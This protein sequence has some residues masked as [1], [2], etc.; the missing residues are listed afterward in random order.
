M[1]STKFTSA[2]VDEHVAYA[3]H[4]PLSQTEPDTTSQEVRGSLA[5]R[6]PPVNPFAMIL[7]SGS[8][9]G[10]RKLRQQRSWTCPGPG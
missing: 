5:P 8:S 7:T 6:Q 3:K 9:A 2:L 4:S 10:S 1:V